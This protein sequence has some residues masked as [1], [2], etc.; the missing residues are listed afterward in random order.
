[1]ILDFILE[2]PGAVAELEVIPFVGE[3]SLA[4]TQRENG[5]GGEEG[6]RISGDEQESPRGELSSIRERETDRIGK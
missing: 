1:M 5:V 6:I 4:G 2:G 3:L